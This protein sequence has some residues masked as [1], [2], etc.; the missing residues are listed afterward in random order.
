MLS[1]GPLGLT[2]PSP[3]IPG[4]DTFTAM[5]AALDAGCNYW[6]GG[7]FYGSPDNNSL[8]LLKRYYENHP[9]D[10]SKVLLNVKGCIAWG[11]VPTLR[12]SIENSV[13][14]LGLRGR[15]DHFEPARKDPNVEIEVSI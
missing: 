9:D 13:R 15:I 2:W 10:A 14:M 12:S 7:E 11:C 8:A 3:S 6:N 1:E 4:E 5:K